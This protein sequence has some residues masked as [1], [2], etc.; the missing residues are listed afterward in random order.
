[1]A[2]LRI[3]DKRYTS[4]TIR[5]IRSVDSEIDP[6]RKTGLTPIFDTALR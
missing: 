3:L 1:M 6:F 2:V 4:I 5:L